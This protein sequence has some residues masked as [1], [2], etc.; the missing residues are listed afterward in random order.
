ML[1][2]ASPPPL[3]AQPPEPAS[4]RAPGSNASVCASTRASRFPKIASGGETVEDETEAAIGAGQDEARPKP[5]AT[6]ETAAAPSVN[7]PSAFLPIPGF[8]TAAAQHVPPPQRA[9]PGAADPRP[10]EAADRPEVVMAHAERE[11][12]FRA[13]WPREESNLRTW[14]RSPPLYPLSYGASP[15]EVALCARLRAVPF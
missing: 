14:I 1:Q 11:P 8:Y 5:T 2:Q 10:F 7:A 15:P 4:I 3:D 13:E 12:D 6:I 9:L